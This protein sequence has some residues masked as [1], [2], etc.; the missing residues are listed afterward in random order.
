MTREQAALGQLQNHCTTERIKGFTRGS[1][2][3]PPLTEAQ[4]RVAWADDRPK[5]VAA[6]AN[7]ALRQRCNIDGTTPET[8]SPIK[9]VLPDADV[10]EIF[11]REVTI[12]GRPESPGPNN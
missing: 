12:I 10:Q 5:F 6:L 4:A 1:G 8:E 11:E 9:G 3:Q 7:A 2:T